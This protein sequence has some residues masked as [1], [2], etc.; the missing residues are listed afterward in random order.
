MSLRGALEP[1]W[2]AL[3]RTGLLSLALVVGATWLGSSWLHAQSDAQIATELRQRARPGDIRMIS[4]VSCFF[5]ARAREWLTEHQIAFDECLIERDSACQAE[6][7]AQ[8]ARGTPTVL[9]RQQVQLGFD[10]ERVAA[11]LRA[12][13]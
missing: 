10:A 2:A 13:P 9:V 12:A 11:A 1:A 3:R 7:L 6:Y 4:S 5:C 8:G